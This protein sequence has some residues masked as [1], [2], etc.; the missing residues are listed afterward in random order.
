MHIVVCIKQTPKTDSVRIDPETG[1]LIRSS[2]ESAMN[3]FDEFALEEA[4][5]V[6]ERVPGSKVTALTMGPLNAE[7]VLR[8]AVSKGADDVVLLSGVEFAG[9]DTYATSLALSKAIEKISADKGAVHLV[10][11]GKQT[12]DSDTGHIGSQIAAR[13]NWP[14]SSFVRKIREVNETSLIA[15]RL[16]ED[17]IEVLEL[18]CPAVISVVKEINTPRIASLKGRMASKKAEVTKW[19]ADDVNC[20]KTQ[21]GIK[22]SP[23][24][25]VRSFSPKVSTQSIKIEGATAKE[26]AENLLNILIEAKLV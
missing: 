20:D 21:L 6:K 19:N 17:G 24:S 4:V 15:E 13:L 26:Q 25:V 14:L 11:C 9:S 1:C 23:T 8:E 12:N 3:P 7:N 16:V 10:I 2:S 5:R 22:G 18:A